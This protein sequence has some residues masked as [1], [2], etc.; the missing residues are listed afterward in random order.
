MQQTASSMSKLEDI[1]KTF[2]PN[3]GSALLFLRNISVINVKFSHIDVEFRKKMIKG[4]GWQIR[5]EQLKEVGAA[6]LFFFGLFV[7][8]FGC[9]FVFVCLFIWLFFLALFLKL[10]T[11]YQCFFCVH[12]GIV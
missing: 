11:T 12:N 5:G 2:V 10:V 8:S 1:I 6:E 7:C 3:L 9:L 4:N